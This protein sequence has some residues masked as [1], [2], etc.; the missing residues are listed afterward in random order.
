MLFLAVIIQYLWTNI[1]SAAYE[2][3]Y[4]IFFHPFV[5]FT[6]CLN[7]LR[8]CSVFRLEGLSVP[9]VYLVYW[10]HLLGLHCLSLWMVEAGDWVQGLQGRVSASSSSA[11]SDNIGGQTHCEIHLLNC[12]SNWFPKRKI[13]DCLMLWPT[14]NIWTHYIKLWRLESLKCSLDQ[15]HALEAVMK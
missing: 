3:V 6:L 1:K 11:E 7:G 13:I 12:N 4:R 5:P 8:D 2:I 10:N 15:F 14:W 9:T